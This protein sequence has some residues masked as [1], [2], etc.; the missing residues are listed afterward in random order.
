M[1]ADGAATPVHAVLAALSA[2]RGAGVSGCASD[3]PLRAVG[4]ALR[5]GDAEPPR[6]LLVNLTARA[7]ACAVG[8]AAAGHTAVRAVAGDAAAL[9]ARD[10]LA[11]V[12]LDAHAVAWLEATARRPRSAAHG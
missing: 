7:L 1:A 6:L 10:G 8:G 4:L 9:P 11:R 3:A 5:A 2:C 12:E